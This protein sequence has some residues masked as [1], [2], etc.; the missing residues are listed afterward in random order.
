MVIF[1]QK[2]T[3]KNVERLLNKLKNFHFFFDK[4]RMAL[5]L[6]EDLKDELL[7]EIKKEFK[8]TKIVRD[9]KEPIL[10]R[11]KKNSLSFLKKDEIFLI[12]GPCSIES[13]KILDKIAKCVKECNGKALRGGSFKPRTSP[14]SF[15]G[16][17]EDGLKIHRDISNKYGLL[18]VSEVLDTRDVELVSKYADILQIGSRNMQNFP[19]LKECAKTF[20]PILLKRNFG[21][22]I[23]EFLLSAEYILNE[24]NDKVILCERGKRTFDAALNNSFDPISL[25]VIKEQTQLPVIVDPSH[26]AEFSKYVGVV[27]KSAIVS[28]ADGL[29]IEIHPEPQYA[30]SDGKQSLNLKE[31]KKLIEEL[32]MVAKVFNKR[33]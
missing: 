6:S 2:N 27:A 3:P 11:K 18:M 15:Q 24:G 14:Y 10:V 19:L 28:D 30:L 20:K 8:I 25:A 23:K 33:F 1:L 32:K 12:A 17:G 29:M 22:T 4:K 13:E 7:S 21:S 31:F 5:Y 26:S 16:L 9:E